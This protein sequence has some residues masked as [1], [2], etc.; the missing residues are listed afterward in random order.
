[1]EKVNARDTMWLHNYYA[2]IR[3]LS[4]AGWGIKYFKRVKLLTVHKR[5]NVHV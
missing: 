5:R 2:F 4:K 1:M 3:T